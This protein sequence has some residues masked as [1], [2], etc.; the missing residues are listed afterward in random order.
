MPLTLPLRL[1]CTTWIPR[2]ILTLSED[3]FAR[4]ED[5]AQSLTPTTEE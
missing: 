5:A 1:L 2:K 3:W 4:C